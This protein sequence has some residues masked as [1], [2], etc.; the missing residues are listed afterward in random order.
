MGGWVV[1]RV[2]VGVDVDGFEDLGVG[3]MGWMSGCVVWKW[4]Y[5]VLGE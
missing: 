4:V 3:W 1:E 5:H 2:D